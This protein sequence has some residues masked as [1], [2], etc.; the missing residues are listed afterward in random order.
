MPVHHQIKPAA[1][2]AGSSAL[3]MIAESTQEPLQPERTQA[4]EQRISASDENAY[5]AGMVQF[6]AVMG[7]RRDICPYRR[8]VP[9]PYVATMKNKKKQAKRIELDSE[10]IA[11]L[12]ASDADT[13]A[14]KGGAAASRTATS[15]TN[16][17]SG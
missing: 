7:H 2:A 8:H 12:E 14:I 1:T 9:G 10:V 3:T 4:A 13:D 15:R 17:E 5:I 6:S 11:D 16:S